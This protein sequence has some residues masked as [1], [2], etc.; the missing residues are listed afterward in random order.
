MNGEICFKKQ[1]KG[2]FLCQRFL[3][4]SSLIQNILYGGNSFD[5]NFINNKTSEKVIEEICRVK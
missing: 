4:K 1:G 2:N 3:F 5:K